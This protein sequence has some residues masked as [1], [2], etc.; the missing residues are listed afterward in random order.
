DRNPDDADLT[1]PASNDPDQP[2]STSGP[3]GTA[4]A[5]DNKIT[6]DDAKA[7]AEQWLGLFRSDRRG[8]GLF[9]LPYADPDLTSVLRSHKGVPLLHDSDVLGAAATKK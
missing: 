8:R 6:N 1:N 2:S 9:G 7:G 5:A 4:T 3:G